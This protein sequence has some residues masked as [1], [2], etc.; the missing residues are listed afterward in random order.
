M[1]IYTASRTTTKLQ[2]AKNCSPPSKTSNTTKYNF[3]S[4]WQQTNTFQWVQGR[5]GLLIS[6]LLWSTKVYSAQTVEDGKSEETERTAQGKYV[7]WTYHTCI[8]FNDQTEDGQPG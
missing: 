5:H 2:Y 4:L 7:H 8:Q 6:S 3:R 1:S